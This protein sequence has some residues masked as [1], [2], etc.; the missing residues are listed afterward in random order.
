MTK[1]WPLLRR[2]LRTA[3]IE[4]R[5]M[6]TY[7]H[8]ADKWKHTGTADRF[9]MGYFCVASVGAFIGSVYSLA[10]SVSKHQGFDESIIGDCALGVAKS[11]AWSFS[12]PFWVPVAAVGV[13]I[14]FLWRKIKKC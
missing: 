12:F 2:A 11:I 5:Q 10:K 3:R 4:S 9:A 1:M 7:H 14:G 6:S 13:P 8:Y